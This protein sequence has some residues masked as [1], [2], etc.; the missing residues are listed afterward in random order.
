MENKNNTGLIVGVVAS[1]I[2]AGGF[3]V[4]AL[5]RDSADETSNSSET[6][7]TTSEST[8]EPAETTVV[9]QPSVVG[10][11]Q[12]SPN[13]STLVTAVVAADLATTLSGEGPFTVFA[14]TNAAF[15]ALPAG[16]LD[17]LLLPENKATLSGILTYHV[18]PGKVM[19]SDLKN[20]QVIT[21]VNGATLTVEIMDG[22]VMLVDAKGNKATVTTADVEASNGVVHIIDSVVLPQ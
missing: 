14:P 9:E 13:L 17:T 20:G 8:V 4:F 3:G 10:L 15:A 11:A 18:V 5:T 21:T 7:Q 2:I 1:L 6:S 12:A 22:K 16:T 19:S